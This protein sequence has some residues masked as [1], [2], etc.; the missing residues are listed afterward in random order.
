MVEKPSTVFSR[1][2][3]NVSY[4]AK[5]RKSGIFDYKNCGR[6]KNARFFPGMSY[7]P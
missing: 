1:E 5:C 2:P 7:I 3:V 6:V 4:M